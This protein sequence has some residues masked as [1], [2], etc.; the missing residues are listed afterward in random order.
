MKKYRRPKRIVFKG[1]T[2]FVTCKT[3]NNIPYFRESIFCDLFVENLRFCKQLKGFWLLSWVLLDNH[4]H[5]MVH[6]N[7]E[8]DIS[9]VMHCLKR[10]F[11]HNANIINGNIIP[12]V[13]RDNYPDLRLYGMVDKF[14]Q[15]FVQKYSNKNPYPKFKWQGRFHDHY[16]RN[17]NDFDYHMEYMTYNPE[18][19]HMPIDWPY[20]F[21]NSQYE[22]LTDE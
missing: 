12:S 19:H 9:E 21:T 6:P 15:S 13:G 18:K 14:R 20:I 7:D 8:F 1:A 3:F 22:D 17:D 11:S 16:I 5:L 10:N 4:F 2:Y